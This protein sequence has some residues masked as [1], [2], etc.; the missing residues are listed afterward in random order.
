MPS[1]FISAI[2]FLAIAVLITLDLLKMRGT[3]AAFLT[4]LIAAPT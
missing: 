1:S 3:E 2:R 4:E